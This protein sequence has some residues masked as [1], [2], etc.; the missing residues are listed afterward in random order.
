MGDPMTKPFSTRVL[1]RMAPEYSKVIT[2][3]MDLSK[4]RRTLETPGSYPSLGHVWADVAQ[5]RLS[6]G[7]SRRDTTTSS[8]PPQ[9]AVQ[10]SPIAIAAPKH[11]RLTLLWCPLSALLMDGMSKRADTAPSTCPLPSNSRL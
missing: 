2:H 1:D 5:V 3:P 9:W 8:R 11:C 6:L 4:I 7:A 10:S